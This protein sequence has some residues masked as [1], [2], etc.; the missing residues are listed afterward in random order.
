MGGSHFQLNYLSKEDLK[1]AK[2]TPDEYRSLRVRV[3]GFS[4]YFVNLN[5]S[6]QDDIIKRT[7]HNG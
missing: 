5:S 2:L 4:D 3:S 6:I 1:K 7:E